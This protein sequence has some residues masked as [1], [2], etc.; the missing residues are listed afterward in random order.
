[1]PRGNVSPP[2]P[3]GNAKSL[4]PFN[5]RHFKTPEE[6]QGAIDEYILYNSKEYITKS[7][8]QKLSIKDG[9]QD[10]NK[11]LEEDLVSRPLSVHGFCSYA[12]IDQDTFTRYTEPTYHY[13]FLKEQGHNDEKM[14]EIAKLFA[15]IC[16]NFKILCAN[17]VAE[18]ALVG[19]YNSGFATYYLQKVHGWQAETQNINNT[20]KVVYITKEEKQ[21]MDDKCDELINNVLD[22]E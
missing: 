5:K 13:K 6:L 22:N 10:K 17:S 7:R 2:N 3:E 14:Q 12:K 16:Q 15:D 9:K 18:R 4:N 1:M 20:G 11:Y 19:A 21:D 8:K